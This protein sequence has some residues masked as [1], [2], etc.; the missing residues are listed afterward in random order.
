[1]FYYISGRLAHRGEGFAVV[2]AAGVGYKINTSL[3][4]LERVGAVG[5]TVKFF[6]YLYVREDIFDLYGFV[7]EEEM[8]MFGMLL[9]VSGIG[10][11]AAVSMLSIASP[12]GIAE[13]IV[14]GDSRMITRAQGVGPKAAQRVILELRDKIQNADMIAQGTS[15]PTVTTGGAASE[16]IEALTMLGYSAAEAKS[17]LAGLDLSQD[18]ELII[19]DALK[20]LVK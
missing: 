7:S 17:A 1:M 15:E 6:T 9:S 19:K 11:K 8:K 13:A 20:K 5:E 16:A 18:L 2:D 3:H 12:S 10:P 4:S 14:T